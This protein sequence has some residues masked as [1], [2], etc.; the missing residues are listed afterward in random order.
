MKL[1]EIL[2]AQQ[3][4]SAEVVIK[5]LKVQQRCRD[6]QLGQILIALGHASPWQV[7]FALVE[8]RRQ[9]TAF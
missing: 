3:I 1:G 2:V 4:L 9:Q 7:E 5:A 6:M 8:Q